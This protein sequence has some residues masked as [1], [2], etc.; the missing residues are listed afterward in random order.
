MA[1]AA[2]KVEY[3]DPHMHTGPAEAETTRLR[4]LTGIWRWALIVLTGVTVFLC[5]NQQFGLRF[6][7]GFTPLN[8]EYFYLLILCMLPFTFLIF[9]GSA[10][11]SLVR[12]PWYDVA[13]FAVTAVAA[14]YLMIHIR[15]AADA[16]T[17]ANAACAPIDED[18]VAC[19]RT[20]VLQHVEAGAAEAADVAA[21][22]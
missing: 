8:T 3:D 12:I 22:V 15:R 6:F 10:R 18:T 14:V 21:G 17:A 2:K 19:D 13:L 11:A 20:S 9:P 16:T 4:P 7:V 1:E 5:I